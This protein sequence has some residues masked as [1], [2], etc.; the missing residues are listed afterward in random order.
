MFKH[1]RIIHVF[2]ILI[3]LALACRIP[4]ADETPTENPPTAEAAQELE[5]TL[6][7]T[8]IPEEAG[9]TESAIEPTNA[10]KNPSAEQTADGLDSCLYGV[11]TADNE[12]MAEYLENAMNQNGMT[13]F[14][15]VSDITGIL[16]MSFNDSAEM[17]MLSEDYLI[18]VAISFS[19]E[20]NMN[21]LIE[22]RA[23]GAADY[24]ADGMVL[25]NR[26]TDL[27]VSGNPL[28]SVLT[29]VSEGDST[30][31]MDVNPDWFLGTITEEAGDSSGTAT[32][33][34]S[35]NTF[36]LQTTEYGAVTFTRT[37]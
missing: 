32:Y 17:G 31:I 35:E 9:D 19:E 30:I 37:E 20:V 11:W 16:Q 24:T 7:V 25:T 28:D 2:A 26:N 23:T 18:P 8:E 36:K 29:A 27:E 22:L 33:T 4:T 5:P 6:P 3:F 21:L 1:K 15:T 34:C 14:F 10:P 12:S 13:D